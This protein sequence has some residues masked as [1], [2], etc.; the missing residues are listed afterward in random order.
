[1]ANLSEDKQELN[2]DISLFYNKMVLIDAIIFNGGAKDH[3]TLGSL[4]TTRR[5]LENIICN[6]RPDLF[7]LEETPEEMKG[8][9]IKL[10]TTKVFKDG[11]NFIDYLVGEGKITTFE[12]FEKMKH[13]RNEYQE[14]L[15]LL[16][17]SA[18]VNTDDVVD[19]D[20]NVE[21]TEQ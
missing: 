13:F 7:G 20:S 4:L 10:D 1:M 8:V 3:E 21:K 9:D 19:A 16:E 17:E 14:C 15:N 18:T 11:I 6:L 5:S 12:D 2:F